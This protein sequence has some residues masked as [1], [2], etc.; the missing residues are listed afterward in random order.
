MKKLLHV[1]S[2]PKNKFDTTKV[3]FGDDWEE[4]RLDIDEE[5]KPDIIA[6]MTDMSVIKNEEFDAIFSSHNIEHLFAYEVELALNEF[7]RV[8]KKGAEVLITCP[9][10]ERVAKE[11]V[12]GRYL[13]TL[14]K[15]R[16]G[17]IA[18]IDILYGHRESLK[19]GK[20]YMAHRV[21]F[22]LKILLG[23]LKGKGFE[24]V[25][26][27]TDQLNLYVLGIKEGNKDRY[28]EQR[29]REH[30]EGMNVINKSNV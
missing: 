6:S 23:L 10:L 25:V 3:F 29:L 14:Y 27:T 19:E 13:E 15:S 4:T 11:I 12:E 28:A 26:G 21:G 30:L 9:D 24:T 5:V 7:H 22:T 17:P 16:A 18:P 2:G 20:H 1:G 8:M